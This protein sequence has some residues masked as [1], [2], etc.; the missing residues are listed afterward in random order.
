MKSRGRSPRGWLVVFPY[1]LTNPFGSEFSAGNMVT[2][3]V[4]SV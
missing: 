2:G 1:V 3:V 4:I